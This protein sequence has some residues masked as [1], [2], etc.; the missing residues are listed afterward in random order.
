MCLSSYLTT[1][2]TFNVKFNYYVNK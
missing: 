2:E 1:I